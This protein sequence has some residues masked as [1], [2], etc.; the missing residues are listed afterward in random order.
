MHRLAGTQRVTG[1][2]RGRDALSDKHAGAHHGASGRVD[3]MP[4]A[5]SASTLRHDLRRLDAFPSLTPDRLRMAYREACLARLHVERVVQECL[6]GKVKFA[7]WGPGEEIHG[8]AAALAFFDAAPTIEHVGIVGHYRSAS[9]LALWCRQQGY[10]DF[11]L[12]HMRQ[13]LSKA[14]DP[15]S[16]GRQMT[17][18]F[19]DLRFG[20]V[21][22][23]SALGMQLG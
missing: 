8:T 22:V 10:N 21:P 11:H 5:P 9:L 6:K 20:V 16:G 15:W 1:A 13:Q 18:H 3:R 19:N 12:D 4:D 7:I 23:Q 14:T 2:P 17:A